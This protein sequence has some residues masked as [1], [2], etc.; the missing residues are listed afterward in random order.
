[1][2]FLTA[3]W[4]GVQSVLALFLPIFGKARAFRG[5]GTGLRWIIHIILVAAIVVGLYFLNQALHIRDDMGGQAYKFIG[6][7]WLPILFLLIYAL[8]WLGWWLYKLLGSEE[9]GSEFPDIDAAW[10]EAMR[11][12]E[13]GGISLLDAPLFLVVGKPAG[14]EEALFL[15]AQL[16]LTVKQAPQRPEAPLHVYANRDGIYVTCAGASLLGQYA[17]MLTGKGDITPAAGAPVGAAH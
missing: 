8:A 7:L 12:L 10:E 5:L 6:P 17:T 15:A 11:A 1:M 2:G 14:S 3:L 13:K 16:Q 9:E 4:N